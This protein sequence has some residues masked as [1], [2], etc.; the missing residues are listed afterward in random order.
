[1]IDFIA[2][3][4]IVLNEA[5]PLPAELVPCERAVGR[6]L[7][8]PL[9]AP[10][11]LP[12]FDNSAVDGYGIRVADFSKVDFT[13]PCELQVSGTVNAGGAASVDLPFQHACK[14]MTGAKIPLGVDAVI[15]REEIE[16]GDT[17]LL[18]RLPKKSENV[19]FAGEEVST[20]QSLLP[21]GTRI[22]PAT[23][24]LLSTFGMTQVPVCMTPKI[25]IVTTGDELSPLETA[26]HDS[27]IHDANTPTLTTLLRQLGIEPFLLRHLPDDSAATQKQLSEIMQQVDIVIST[28]GVSMGDRDF[29]RST[30]LESGVHE[31]FWKVA[32]K[33]GKP[34]FFGTWQ[35]DDSPGLFFGLPGNP[36]AV[37]VTFEMFVIPAIRLM[38]GSQAPLS[39]TFE[40]R[41][42]NSIRKK[43]GRLEFLRACVAWQDGVFQAT[44]MKAQESHML[45]GMALA[46]AL[47]HFQRDAETM[48]AGETITAQF[49]H[50]S[51]L[52]HV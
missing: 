42:T 34:I 21:L 25:A 12:R 23:L 30:A 17:V 24:G 35:R 41:L 32:I 20:G 38:L 3:R 15:M 28:G 33:P 47:L 29:V 49:L 48:Q 1:M 43:S 18:R 26:L 52:T 37:M 27:Q 22:S 14:I 31:H 2:A 6:Y 40:A 16:G 13:Q 9:V 44:P 10:F 19:R 45:S 39:M 4:Q 7:R 50:G 11:Q 46:N 36:V 51:E 8:E 5:K